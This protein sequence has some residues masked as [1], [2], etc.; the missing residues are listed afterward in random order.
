M[1]KAKGEE[2]SAQI[3]KRWK[4]SD[5]KENDQDD[6]DAFLFEETFL[7]TFLARKYLVY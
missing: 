6:S 3:N 4:E 7:K 2:K 1:K 5:D